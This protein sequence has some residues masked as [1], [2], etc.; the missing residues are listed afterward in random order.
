MDPAYILEIRAFNRWYTFLIG[1]LDRYYLNSGY[2]LTE[3]RVLYEIH[4]AEGGIT[5]HALTALLGLDKGYLSRMLRQFEKDKLLDKK[6]SGT[7]M[8]SFYLRLSKKGSSGSW[9]G[10]RRSNWCSSSSHWRMRICAGW[11]GI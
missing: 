4:H 11:W 3:V 10:R 7:D 5:A 1:L 6:R 2:S 8:R 9:T